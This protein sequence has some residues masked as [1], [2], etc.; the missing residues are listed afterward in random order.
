MHRT[1]CGGCHT[2]G[3]LQRGTSPAALALAA[4]AARPRG[5]GMARVL[6]EAATGAPCGRASPRARRRGRRAPPPRASEPGDGGGA[7]V[8][9]R[10]VEGDV[11][12]YCTTSSIAAGVDA[13]DM[14]ARALAVV[15]A[16]Q[17]I[18]PAPGVPVQH[19]HGYVYARRL[20]RA[21]DGGGGADAGAVGEDE[22]AAVWVDA[23]EDVQI[24]PE[25]LL[26]IVTA[27][28]D[29]RAEAGDEASG[30]WRGRGAGAALAPGGAPDASSE[31]Q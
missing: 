18:V 30:G 2:A 21:D 27:S 12:A 19:E 22:Q 20:R 16:V 28:Y 26:D 9:Q 24:A 14:P 25:D 23:G 3:A 10:V 6:R 7:S 13:S 17:L 29:G 31:R 15:D 11:V 4:A 8:A 5:E 1:Q